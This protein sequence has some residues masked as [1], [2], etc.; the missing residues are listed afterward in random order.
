MAKKNTKSSLKSSKGKNKSNKSSTK[1]NLSITGSQ[2]QNRIRQR[3]LKRPKYRTFKL[4]KAIKHS[5]P[6]IKGSIKLFAVSFQQI[7]RARKLFLGITAIYTLLILLLVRGF[8]ISQD[9]LETRRQLQETLGSEVSSATIGIGL[10]GYLISSTNQLTASSGLYSS[11][12]LLIFS[13]AIIWALRQAQAAA[14]ARIRD[15]FYIGLRPIGPFVTILIII[16]LQLIPLFVANFLFNVAF[17]N[18]VAVGIL[19]KVFSGTIIGLLAVLSLYLVTS[20]LFALYIVTLPDVEPGQALKSAR[21]L[22]AFRRWMVMRRIL[23]LGFILLIIVITLILPM[24]FYVT[25]LAE[26]LF[27][28]MSMIFP[29][30]IH[31]Y[32]YNLYKEL[33]Q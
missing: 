10:F 9:L 11:L 20:S 24:L 17:I 15:A 8:S 30:I 33:L 2:T 23:S 13:L 18:G 12:L 31:A 28:G 3:R 21:E 6:T 7:W 4:A 5:R 22:V 27:F 26:W 14:P 32:M 16:A 19:E 25:R 1:D 29:V